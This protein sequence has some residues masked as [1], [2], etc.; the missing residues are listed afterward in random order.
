MILPRRCS[1]MP[2]ATARASMNV[3]VRLV[4]RTSSHSSSVTSTDR[5][6]SVMP[7]LLTRMCDRTERGADVRHDGVDLV[8]VG[9]VEPEA[10]RA[11]AISADLRRR[12]LDLFRGARAA[13]HRGARGA[14]R[15]GDGAADAAARTRDQG[16][17]P[18]ERQRLRHL[19]G[20]ARLRLDLF[21]HDL[22]EAV[23]LDLPARRHRELRDDLEALRKLH[24]R[25]LLGVEVCHQLGER[26][27]LA[28]LRDHEAQARSCSRGSGM[29]TT[30]TPAILG[31]V[32]SAFST[33]A[34]GIFSPPRM[35]TSLDRPV[36]ETYPSGSS[37]ARSPVLNQPSAVWPSR[38][39]SGRFRSTR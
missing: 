32:K 36:M 29:A 26:H 2:G 6:S 15:Q 13:C 38:V 30:A 19:S 28:I 5:L 11:A 33:S 39:N 17:P 34:T 25:E 27:R 8:P 9:D 24:L 18:R 7:A 1:I 4:A 3:E 21:L 23:L 14:E 37:V 10:A 31:W 16:D 20:A 22:T 12:R 35:I